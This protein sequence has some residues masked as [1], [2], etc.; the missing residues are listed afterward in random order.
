LRGP[1]VALNSTSRRRIRIFTV[2]LLIVILIAIA[3]ALPTGHPPFR[4]IAFFSGR[5]SLFAGA[6][7]VFQRHRLNAGFLTAWDEMAAFLGV[8]E[9][10]RLITA[11]AN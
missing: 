8:A 7:A 4:A 1:P 9:V 2:K 11:F 6:T 3:F 5:Q 10:A